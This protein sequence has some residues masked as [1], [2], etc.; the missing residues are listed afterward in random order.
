MILSM[1]KREERGG[2]CN[3]NFNLCASLSK[4]YRFDS[5]RSGSVIRICL[6]HVTPSRILIISKNTYT[7]PVIRFNLYL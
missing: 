1:F 4:S 3:G 6:D 7:D 5:K 2:G